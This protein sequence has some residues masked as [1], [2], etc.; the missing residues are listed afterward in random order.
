MK[1][2]LLEASGELES[3][4]RSTRS[5]FQPGTWV[6]LPRALAATLLLWRKT[7]WGWSQHVNGGTKT[8]WV[9]W[10]QHWAQ[11]YLLWCSPIPH[12]LKLPH[13][14]LSQFVTT[15]FVICWQKNSYTGSKHL[16]VSTYSETTDLEN[17]LFFILILKNFDLLKKKKHLRLMS[18]NLCVVTKDP[19]GIFDKSPWCFINMLTCSIM[20][21]LRGHA[22]PQKLLFIM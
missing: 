10:R 4:E 16:F 11:I 13:Y 3:Y 7:V 1:R 18:T 5:H 14:R 20:L 8:P 9:P 21:S 22:D 17:D 2:G 12:T 6:R 19:A 15:G